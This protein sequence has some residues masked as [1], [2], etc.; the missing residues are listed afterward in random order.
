MTLLWRQLF[1][2]GVEL[3]LIQG[4]LRI[5]KV[6]EI[7]NSHLHFGPIFTDCLGLSYHSQTDRLAERMIQ[8]LEDMIRR[9]RAYGLELKASDGFTHDWCTLIPALELA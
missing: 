7:P 6:T 3:F 9:F 8:T 1:F 2:Y 4:Y 5:F